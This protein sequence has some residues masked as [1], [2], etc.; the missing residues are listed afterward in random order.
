[1]CL[2]VH[3]YYKISDFP[4]IIEKIS[5]RSVGASFFRQFL[6][7]LNHKR[8]PSNVFSYSSFSSYFENNSI[9]SV[10]EQSALPFDFD[11]ISNQDYMAV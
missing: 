6:R 10:R 1:M 8:H 3:L 2:I 5:I 11:R 9:Q 4:Y 7:E